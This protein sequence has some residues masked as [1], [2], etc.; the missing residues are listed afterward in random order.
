MRKRIRWSVVSVSLLALIALGMPPSFADHNTR[1]EENIKNIEWV[2]DLENPTPANN[3]NSDMAFWGDLLFQGNFKGFRI[4]D[5]SD[6]TA[7]QVVA[8]VE[9]CTDPGAGTFG[10]GQGDM[11]IWDDLLIRTWDV[12]ASD[13]ATCDG[14]PVQAGFEGLHL[15]DVSTPAS[16][17]LVESIP[18]V[19]G[20]ITVDTVGEF[21]GAAAQSGPGL[22]DTP[23][24]GDMELVNDGEGAS[25]TDACEGVDGFTAGN[26][27]L[28]DRTPVGQP[29]A[30]TCSAAVQIKNAQNAGAVAAIVMNTLAGAA[31]NLTG[32]DPTIT[33]PAL[34]VTQATGTALKAAAGSEASLAAEDTGPGMPG[35][36]SHT[37]TGVPDEAND[38]LLVYNGGSNT[39]CRGMDLVDIP[40]A[41]P[42]DAE[43]YDRA[44]AIPTGAELGRSCHDITVYLVDKLRAVCSGSWT[45]AVPAPPGPVTRHGYAYF[46]MDSGG[47]TLEQPALLYQQDVPNTATIGHTSTFSWDGSVL[48]WSHEPGGGVAAECEIT[49]PIE[50]RQLY[51]FR[52]ETGNEL[53]RWT[54]PSQSAQENCASVHI[55]QSIPTTNGLDVLASGTYQAGTYV[56]DYTNPIDRAARAIGWSDPPPRVPTN[57]LAGA[58]TTYW[59]NGFLYESDILYG[60]HVMRSTS[61]EAQTRVELD[62]LNP[63]TIM[64]FE[65][66]PPLCRGQEATHFGTGEDDTITGSTGDD[67]IAGLG[68]GDEINSR[69]G[70]DVVCAGGGADTVGGGPGDDIL[71]GED[72]RD[73]LIGGRGT[74]RCV[75]GDGIDSATTCERLRSIP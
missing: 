69:G 22:S 15:F 51:F 62:F 18:L 5:I 20:E 58:W 33:I 14:S 27:A 26:V 29:G 10:G 24:T 39:I 59:Y 57:L 54:I 74:D 1:G 25:N 37:A 9:N 56:I 65:V 28:I 60:L 35:C 68:G 19:G 48:V 12:P 31:T 44:E 34:H 53:G 2:A 23:V 43:W 64:P 17:T 7:P 66:P 30:T 11:I 13:T 67:I 63:Q 47:G 40:L 52:A 32:F 41:T 4:V 50:N 36:G 46:S 49:D 55:F 6:P 38:R 8:D 61:P 73:T 72:G 45:D 42:A 70:N 21:F 16:P 71:L 75:G 3:V